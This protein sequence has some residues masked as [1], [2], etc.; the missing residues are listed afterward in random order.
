MTDTE[1]SIECS[2]CLRATSHLVLLEKSIHENSEV[3]CHDPHVVHEYGCQ[4]T[5]FECQG[6]HNVVLK[7]ALWSTELDPTNDD[8]SYISWHP[9]I[10]SR[11]LPKWRHDLADGQID[12]MSQ[13]YLALH[14]GSYSLVLMGLRTILDQYLVCLVG[15]TGTFKSKLEEIVKLGGLS[16]NQ[17]LLL[18]P[19]IDAGSAAAHRGFKPKEDVVTMALEIVENLLHQSVLAKNAEVIKDATPKREKPAG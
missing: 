18:T 10:R 1:Q 5:L 7:K 3:I 9:P 15:D 11:Q 19:V 8:P 12:L 13:I 2:N 16:A 14:S 6:C 4:Y 17:V